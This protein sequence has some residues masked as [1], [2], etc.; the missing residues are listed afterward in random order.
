MANIDH[1]ID[2][3]NYFGLA[4]DLQKTT[5]MISQKQEVVANYPA[6]LKR[7]HHFFNPPE[8]QWIPLL[9]SCNR[10]FDEIEKVPTL[11]SLDQAKTS[12]QRKIYQACLKTAD[13]AISNLS[14]SKTHKIKTQLANLIQRV[15]A[16]QY[17]IEAPNGGLDGGLRCLPVDPILTERLSAAA[18]EWKKNHPLIIRKDLTTREIKKLE[19]ASTYPQFA[20]VVLANRPLQ[21]AFFSWTLRDNNGVSQFVQFPATCSRIKSTYLASRVGRLGGTMFP[22]QKKEKE[23]LQVIE[24]V[25]SLPFFIRNKIEYISLLDESQEVQLNNGWRLTIHQIFQIFSKKNKEVGNLEFFESTGIANWNSQELGPWNPVTYSYD[26]IDL[27]QDQWWKSLPVLEEIS[28]ERLESRIGESITDQEWVAWAKSAR[29]TPDMDLQ[30]RHGYVEVAIPTGNGTYAI[31]P[32][33][34][35]ASSFPHTILELVLFI[36]NTV[37]GKISYPDENFFYS[38]R[39]QAAHPMKLTQDQGH[40]LMKTFQKELIKARFGNV[41]FQFGGENCAFWAQRVL[42]SIDKNMPNFYKLDFLQSTPLDPVL[43]RL[44]KFF[45]MVPEVLRNSVIKAADILLGSGR[46][47]EVFENHTRVYKSHKQSSPRNE[48]V[49]YQ[50]GYLHRQIEEGKIKGFLSTGNC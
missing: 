44:F 21:E 15:A 29:T 13:T 30:G 6:S 50:P 26:R 38:H 48:C 11:F 1:I 23:G 39:Q 37:K 33:G 36:T 34:N 9:S 18:I 45:R 35:F 24:K 42:N 32:F 12:D 47:I 19:E 43:G 25:V 46:T 14:C 16:L 3:N 2:K 17:R 49:I 28:K 8:N 7:L 31:Y 41:I 5:L 20:D 4:E 27:T 40:I 22:I 10:L